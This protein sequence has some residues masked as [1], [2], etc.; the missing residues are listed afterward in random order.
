MAGHISGAVHVAF[1]IDFVLVFYQSM[2]RLSRM[3]CDYA[4]LCC[5]NYFWSRGVLDSIKQ[6]YHQ[7]DRPIERPKSLENNC[8]RVLGR[9][10]CLAAGSLVQHQEDKNCNCSDQDNS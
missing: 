2:W 7:W 4:V 1:G 3:D 10:S 5:H 8:I 6:D 9:S